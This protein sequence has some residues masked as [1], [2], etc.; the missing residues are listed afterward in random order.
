MTQQDH[1]RS[2]DEG[3]LRAALRACN[4]GTYNWDVRSDTFEFDE[5]VERL[6]GFAQ[7]EGGSLE[8]YIARIHVDDRVA[9]LETLE[10]CALDGRDFEREYRVVDPQ[11]QVR[12]LLDKG[13][14][15]RDQGTPSSLTGAVVDLTE[16]KKAERA[17]Q[18]ADRRKDE[19]LAMLGHELRNPLA[20]LRT[21]LDLLRLTHGG[22]L[23]GPHAVMDRQ[24]GILSRLVDDLLDVSRITRGRVALRKESLDLS[25]VVT[26]AVDASAAFIER[27][28]HQLTVELPKR[29]MFIVGDAIRLEQVVTN[30]LTNAAKYTE[31]GGSIRVSLDDDD[32]SV[33]LRVRDTGVGLDAEML[34]GGFELFRQDERDLARSQGGLGLGLTIVRSIVELHGGTVGVTS[35]GRGLGSE[36]FVRLP[37]DCDAAD[38]APVFGL[39]PLDS[40]QEAPCRVLVVDD[41]RD[42]AELL[43]ELLRHF[44]ADA[45]MATSGEEALQLAPVFGPDL[46][47]LDIGMPGM[48][49]YETARRLQARGHLMLVAMTGYG[50]DEDRRRSAMAG[51]SRHLVKPIRIEQLSELLDDLAR[52]R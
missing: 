37:R 46:V 41:N 33:V 47:L 31:P 44:G 35:P 2:L 28:R 19:F 23:D 7:G 24:V 34:Q 43:C 45:Q 21:A 52:V 25:R 22:A 11:G 8:A 51:F 15:L 13:T 20:S 39:V 40:S 17:L 4:I 36:F 12:W 29:P 30:L 1:G 14:W 38:A 26:A 9:W 27:Q 50:Q 10:Q 16:Q 32:E 5:G 6:F 42:G 48:D 18:Q 3:R 49:G